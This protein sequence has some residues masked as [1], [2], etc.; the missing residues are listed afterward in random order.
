MRKAVHRQQPDENTIWP[1]C[2]DV[3][4]LGSLRKHLTAA[5]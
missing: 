4:V 2:D 3:L 1:N 5:H